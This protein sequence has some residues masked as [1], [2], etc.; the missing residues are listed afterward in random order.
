M[1]GLLEGGSFEVLTES[2]GTVTSAQ[3]H[4]VPNFRQCDREY[5]GA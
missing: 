5:R 2:V 3:R 4:T 1:K